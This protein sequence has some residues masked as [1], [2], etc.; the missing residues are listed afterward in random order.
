MKLH[1]IREGIA[2]DNQS[3]SFVE[4]LGFI[5]LM[6]ETEPSY[7]IPY[8]NYFHG[9][10]FP[11]VYEDCKEKISSLLSIAQQISLTRDNWT[12]S[13]INHSF[14]S[15]TGHWISRFL[16]LGVE[17]SGTAF[18]A[19]GHCLFCDYT[20]AVL[21]AKHFPGSHV[22]EALRV[23]S[24]KHFPGSHRGEALSV[25]HFPRSHRGE[26]LSVFSAKH[27]PVSHR[28]ALSVLSAKQFPFLS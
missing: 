17:R 14:I 24:E 9:T 13:V 23:L 18:R 11:S 19:S 15:V 26:T 21:S 25:K 12:N 20:T 5:R 1:K 8:I 6:R 22:G 3:L 16:S 2:F 7:K 28:E 27:F 10:V 4:D